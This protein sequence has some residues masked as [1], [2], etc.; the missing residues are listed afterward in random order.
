M[1]HMKRTSVAI[2]IFTVLWGLTMRAQ[3]P[4][5]NPFVGMWKLNLQRSQSSYSNPPNYSRLRGYQDR[6]GGWMY[7]TI[8]DSIGNAADFT[9]AAVRYDGKEYPVYTS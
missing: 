3:A 5:V 2:G 6:G 7:H 4:E 1:K 9:F 8:I